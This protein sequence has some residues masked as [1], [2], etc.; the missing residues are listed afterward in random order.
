MS[1]E[2]GDDFGLMEAGSDEEDLDEDALE[3]FDDFED[4]GSDAE[5]EETGSDTGDITEIVKSKL[6]TSTKSDEAERKKADKKLEKRLEIHSQKKE[7]WEELAD[8]IKEIAEKKLK[9]KQSEKKKKVTFDDQVLKTDEQVEEDELDDE[10][11]KDE[12]DLNSSD[13]FEENEQ[14]ESDIEESEGIEGHLLKTVGAD[15]DEDEFHD[16]DDDNDDGMEQFEESGDNTAGLSED[17][18]G[19]LRDKEGNIVKDNK[20]AGGEGAYVPPARRLQM[21]GNMNEKRKLQMERLQKQLKGLVN[22][23]DQILFL[24]FKTWLKYSIYL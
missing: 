8:K 15:S 3:E 23:L 9:A 20:P 21:T 5:V 22:R 16:D 10:N 1:E 12:G 6:E 2:E 14:E 7:K 13:D 18:Y 11:V 4:S 17:I 19:R 24:I